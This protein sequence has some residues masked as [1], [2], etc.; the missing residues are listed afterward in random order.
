MSRGWL[1]TAVRAIDAVNNAVG[2]GVA[3]LTALM[4]L[5]YCV[6]VTLR[7]G[8]GIGWV[9]LQESVTYMHAA[10]F[11]LA[12]AYTLN[13]N[14]HVRVDIFYRSWPERRRQWVELIGSLVLL[15]PMAVFLFAVSLGYVADSWARLERSPEPGGLP[16]VYLLKS[17]MLVMAVQ[18]GAAGLSRAGKAVLRL[19]GERSA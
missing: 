5:G 8:F 13:D 6:V 15:L 3:W 9:A 19:T 10:V 2:R 4:V 7:Y 1:R 11:M 17:L 12:A 14:G 18:L 16:F